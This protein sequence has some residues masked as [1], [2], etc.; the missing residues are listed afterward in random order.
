ML[1]RFEATAAQKRQVSKIEA[2]F[3]SFLPPIKF[4]GGMSKMSKSIFRAT[5]MTHTLIYIWQSPLGGHF[6]CM[7]FIKL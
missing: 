7:W 1:L 4:R 6:G 3:R 2:K 5:F